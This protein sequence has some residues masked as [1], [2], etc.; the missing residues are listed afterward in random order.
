[1]GDSGDFYVYGEIVSTRLVAWLQEQGFEI[2]EGLNFQKVIA[3]DGQFTG[4]VALDCDAVGGLHDHE[5]WYYGHPI[6]CGG[7][8]ALVQAIKQL[9]GLE[10]AFAQLQTPV[11]GGLVRAH[12]Y[13]DGHWYVSVDTGCMVRE[14]QITQAARA[15]RAALAPYA[16]PDSPVAALGPNPLEVLHDLLAWA[17]QMGGWDAP[18]WQKARKAV[19]NAA[20]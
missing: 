8:D 5:G 15:A 9:D 14:D 17:E 1:M 3:P 2:Q 13:V 10:S 20:G 6:K 4:F 7:F 18:C 11:A 12:K 19:R 16:A